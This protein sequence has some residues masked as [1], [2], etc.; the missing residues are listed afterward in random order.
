VRSFPRNYNKEAD[1]IAKATALLEPLPPDVFY[2]T[3]T[4]KSAADEA[5]PPKFVNAIQSEDWRAPIV[6]ALK[7]YYEAED[8][9]ITKRVAIRARNYH[10]V[11]GNLYRRGVCA[12]LLKCISVTEGK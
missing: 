10:L 1:A 6:A 9:V 3:T 12:P 2:E 11:D 8:G 5:A 7:G 4:S